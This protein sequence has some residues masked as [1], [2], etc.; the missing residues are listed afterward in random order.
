[1]PKFFAPEK[2]KV[3]IRDRALVYW[4]YDSVK[5]SVWT[6]DVGKWDDFIEDEVY[7]RI[8]KP[9]HEQFKIFSGVSINTVLSEFKDLNWDIWDNDSDMVHHALS[10]SGQEPNASTVFL[11]S[12][13]PTHVELIEWLKDDGVLVYLIA[14][15]S[16][17]ESL[18]RAVGKKRWINLDGL[19]GLQQAWNLTPG[20][21]V[22]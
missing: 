4:D 22:S 18:I 3:R 11:I 15:S 19:P 13:D 9:T 20:F 1:M 21:G 8:P 17:E 2:P 6:E 16:V 12:T 7:K 5:P 10:E 14:P